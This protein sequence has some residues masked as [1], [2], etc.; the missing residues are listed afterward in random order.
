M[1]AGVVRGA[2]PMDGRDLL[3]IDLS[4]GQAPEG[5]SASVTGG[6]GRRGGSAIPS[7]MRMH[8]DD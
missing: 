4:D 1:V 3:R 5:V 6:H 2:R 7:E 8:G